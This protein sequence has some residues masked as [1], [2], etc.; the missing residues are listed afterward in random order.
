M[1][2]VNCKMIKLDV[3][4]SYMRVAT[5]VTCQLGLFPEEAAV[6]ALGHTLTY[7][8]TQQTDDGGD[9]LELNSGHAE[10]KNIIW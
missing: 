3:K 5:G 1:N 4:L 2:P 9:V 7:N 8:A 10:R 6:A